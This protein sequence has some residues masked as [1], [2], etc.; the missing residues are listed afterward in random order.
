MD[1]GKKKR[2]LFNREP[3]E[4]ELI[5]GSE[6]HERSG[7]SG[8]IARIKKVFI[9]H[10]LPTAHLEHE[11]L[12]KTQALA[13]FASDALSSVAY[14][15]EEILLVLA[16]AGLAATSF[17][18]GIALA[19]AILLWIVAYS[20]RQTIFHYPQGGGTYRVSK[21][22]FGNIPALIAGSALM[23]DYVLTVAVSISAGVS[24]VTSAFPSLYPLRVDLALFALLFISVVNL[25][26]TR[27]S[28]AVFALPTYF[29]IGCIF[30]ML[31]VGVY[32]VLIGA[33][34]VEPVAGYLPTVVQPIG[35]L[36]LLRAFSSG[37]SAMTGTEAI[38]DGVSAFK[39]PQAKNA[40]FTLMWM[41]LILSVMFLGIS[42]LAQ[43]YHI[44]PRTGE[45]VISQL[46]RAVVGRGWFYYFIQAAT[47]LILFLAAN[48]SYSDFPR[49]AYF[50]AIDRFL[51]RQFVYRGDRL[52]F[53]TGIVAL[54]LLSG[55]LIYLVRADVH[56]LIP[57]YAVGVFMSFT[58]SQ[59]GMFKRWL[60]K[61]EPG[62]KQGMVINGIGALT[63]GLVAIIIAVSKFL[64]GAWMVVF[65][66]P[67]FVVTFMGINVHYERVAKYLALKGKPVIKESEGPT[68]AL[69]LISGVN[70]ATEKLVEYALSVSPDV[71]ALHVTDDLE[72]A[73]SLEKEWNALELSIPLVILESPF[74]S[75]VGPILKYLDKIQKETTVPITI[76][77]SAF[78]PHHWWEYLLHN[79]DGLRLL[80][81]LFF[82]PNIAM[83]N[84]PYHL[85]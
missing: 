48:T 18:G 20:Y 2:F 66:L 71:T 29:F 9:G 73:K 6:T 17:T 16:T 35:N 63:T 7:V 55:I 83:S 25:R 39:A 70:R 58:F 84:F 32:R 5:P 23:I 24:A 14:A 64:T 74:R 11:R 53:S 56:R 59:A 61:K 45:T 77:I 33:P 67:F 54:A 27:E 15:T 68:K 62:W 43:H 65:L 85:E 41:A 10:P 12:P 60:T 44:L 42:F 47:A 31:G 1:K 28:A 76:I 8:A 80:I 19:I 21:D 50:M 3:R 49:L 82:R 75:L 46:A 22:N 78:V 72:S 40:A 30:T 26:G 36:L 81:A 38:S 69:I 79:Q 37:C 52:A 4:P 13:I 51:P 34:P 57:L